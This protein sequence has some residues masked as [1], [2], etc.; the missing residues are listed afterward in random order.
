MVWWASVVGKQVWKVREELQYLFDRLNLL[1]CI[2]G[3]KQ[4]N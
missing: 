1:W 4:D 2:E 3:F